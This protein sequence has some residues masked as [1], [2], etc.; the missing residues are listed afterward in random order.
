MNLALCNVESISTRMAVIRA[1]REHHASIKLVILSNV[2]NEKNG[3]F[4]KQL[5]TNL[6]KRGLAFT[7]YLFVSF[8]WPSIIRRLAR[9][10]KKNS[11]TSVEEI[12]ERFSIP[13]IRTNNVNADNIAALIREKDI[14]II[15]IFYF[16]QI[17]SQPLIDLAKIGVINF[18]PSCLPKCRGLFPVFYSFLFNGGRFGISAHLVDDTKIDAGPIIYQVEIRNVSGSSI[19]ELERKIFSRFPQV[20]KAVIHAWIDRDSLIK[21]HNHK[22]GTYF[23]YPTRH[24]IS[25]L[26]KAGL[27]FFS[28]KDFFR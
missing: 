12:C 25:E 23:S 14:D 5:A 7:G 19:I 22:E 24:E 27:V 11:M 4:V 6:T 13:V 1:I 18:H 17:L 28:L 16:D 8:C 9:L 2:Y 26:K 15:T 21:S 20:F 3:G 10:V